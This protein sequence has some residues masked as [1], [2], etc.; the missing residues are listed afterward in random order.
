MR[1]FV[2]FL[3]VLGMVVS[4]VHS[5]TDVDSLAADEQLLKAA[6]LGTDGPALLDFFRKRT[7]T[8]AD[9]EQIRRLIERLGDDDF[10]VREK[11]RA[12]VLRLGPKTSP[13]LRL[14]RNERDAEFARRAEDCLRLLEPDG[15]NTPLAL[16]A[17]AVRLLAVRKPAGAVEVLLGYLPFADGEAVVDEIQTT[18]AAVAVRQGKPEPALLTA[19]TAA[20]PV[21]RA[22]A[23]AALVK[24]GIAETK[25]SVRKLLH[26]PEPRV[27]LRIGLALAFARDKDAVPVL[28]DLLN[29]LPLEN[30]LPIEDLLCRLAGDKAPAV[31]LGQDAA[32]QGKCRDAWAAWWREHG[33]AIHMAAL[34]GAPPLRGFTL[35]ACPDSGLVMEVDKGGK[36]RWQVR[37]LQSPFDAQVLPGDRILV[38]EY[39]GRV[40]ERNLKGEILWQH[41]IQSAMQC[42]RLAN[43]K[44]FVVTIKKLLEVDPK[45]TETVLYTHTRPGS[46]VAAKK[47]RSGQTVAI[48]SDGTCMKLD[49]A[50]KV[51]SSFPVGKISNNCLDVLPNGHIVVAFFFDGAVAEFD[52]EGKILWKI[53]FPSAF[54][55]HRLPNGNTLLSCHQPPR[56]VELDRAGKVVW[57]Q[58][59]LRPWFASRR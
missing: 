29:K 20:A 14:A 22:V 55:P 51:L 45:G 6:K 21:R 52:A 24:A 8:D 3:F 17:A 5:G 49:A 34:E 23:G 38:A 54:S 35:I 53:A 47:L 57:E 43:G 7:L 31:S 33:A 26:D 56:L 25:A 42:Q 41:E 37:G 12:E 28:I 27:R 4:G 32:S 39:G 58:K 40:S 50:G 59:A 36:T 13:L 46:L 19:L 16:S 44:T 10:G 18:L 1:Y 11:A 48:D 9:C 30:S 15:N 2:T